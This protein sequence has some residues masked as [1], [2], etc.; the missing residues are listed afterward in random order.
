VGCGVLSV[1]CGVGLGGDKAVG[2]SV[3]G[4]I[5]HTSTLVTGH[6]ARRV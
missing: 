1:R 3:G 5:V 2:V 4:G 6:E